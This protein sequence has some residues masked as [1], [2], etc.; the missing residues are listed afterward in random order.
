MGTSG[1][2]FKLFADILRCEDGSGSHAFNYTISFA[3]NVVTIQSNADNDT[4]ANTDL[5]LISVFD[6]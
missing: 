2:S 4:S 3:N 6:Y 1:T 5:Y